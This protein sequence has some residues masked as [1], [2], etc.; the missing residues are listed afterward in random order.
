[1]KH[2]IS[3]AIIEKDVN[4]DIL[5]T[6]E[7]PELDVELE[8]IL[9]ARSNLHQETI[10]IRFS[11]S[12]YKNE[13]IYVYVNIRNPNSKTLQDIL[14][15]SLC[16]ISTDFNPEKYIAL[17]KI[18]SD[19]YVSTGDPLK[20]L[21]CWLRV[22]ARG[23]YSGGEIG[24]FSASDYDERNAYLATSIKD[25]IRM[26]RQ[27]IIFVWAALM[28]KKR[29][30]V[31]SDKLGIL[32]KVIRAFP[33]LVWHRQSWAILR[34]YVTLSPNEISDLRTTAVYCAGFV[35]ES[36]SIR[37]DLFDIFVNV[38]NRSISVASHSKGDFLMTSIHK[39][40][41]EFMLKSVE[42]GN[43]SDQEVIKG[44]AF[45]IKDLLSKIETLKSSHEDGS[46]V[47]W[48]TLQNTKLPPNVD[49]FLYSIAT[50]EGMTRP[51]MESHVK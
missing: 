10:P 26:F 14:A 49:H 34:P 15:F 6:W 13:W 28:M 20:V 1:M 51:S 17:C 9:L 36:I 37:E 8:E 23:S 48:K 30:V 32:L 31:Y 18:M 43:I 50:A 27:E 24:D 11:F 44:L 46:Y 29:I 5:P 19:L 42:A 21:E 4:E 7:Y 2:L 33:L 16:V 39:D 12:R 45:K 25:V 41:C 40:V 22:F 38:N 35:D 47:D 3:V